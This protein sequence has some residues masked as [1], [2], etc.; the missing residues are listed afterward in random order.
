LARLG[1]NRIGIRSAPL[2]GSLIALGIAFVL[3]NL[4]FSRP[5]GIDL[6]GGGSAASHRGLLLI[7]AS[8]FAHRLGTLVGRVFPPHFPEV[9][10]RF[11]GWRPSPFQF[12]VQTSPRLRRTG[13]DGGPGI[14]DAC[15]LA[16]ESFESEGH[17]SA[18]PENGGV[19]TAVR[20]TWVNDI[21]KIGLQG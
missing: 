6:R 12:E 10:A 19:A 13:R 7:L 21:L 20:C 8:A 14:R 17:C 15:R 5:A 2:D 3:G 11:I 4:I 18:N 16:P 9:A 1:R